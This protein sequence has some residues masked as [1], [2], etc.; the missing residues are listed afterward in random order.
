MS[1]E[2]NVMYSFIQ[3]PSVLFADASNSLFTKTFE[4]L[5][6]EGLYMSNVLRWKAFVRSFRRLCHFEPIKL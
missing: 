1:K 6:I 4:C 3:I 5:F 2:H